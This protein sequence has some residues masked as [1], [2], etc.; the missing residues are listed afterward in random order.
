MLRRLT[1]YLIWLWIFFLPWQTRW[2]ISDPMLEGS[3]W[4]YGRISLYAG[5]IIF[6]VM[7]IC[8]A[9]V[10]FKQREKIQIHKWQFLIFAAFI[11][12]TGLSFIWAINPSVSAHYLLRLSQGILFLGILTI[13]RPT[14][15]LIFSSL[16]ISAFIQSCIAVGQFAFQYSPA[17]KW[18]GL[19]GH[20][21]CDLGQ[22][23]IETGSG[24]FLRA[25]GSLP[26]PNILG[27]FLMFGFIATCYAYSNI[28]SYK[29]WWFWPAI[30]LITQ[31]LMLCFSRSAWIGLAV[32]LSFVLLV[33]RKNKN[34]LK[35]TLICIAVFAAIA[36]INLAANFSLFASRIEAVN[37]IETISLAEREGQIDLSVQAIRE[38]PLLGHGLGNYTAWLQEAVPGQPG[39][40]YQPVHNQYLLMIAEAGIIGFALFFILIILLFKVRI[41]QKSPPEKTYIYSL[42]YA[43]LIIGLFDHY[44]W[45]S[46]TGILLFGLLVAMLIKH[47]DSTL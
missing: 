14:Y 13:A 47:E 16:I 23:V 46:Y 15:K 7:V 24:R 10:W 37:R 9:I 40:F 33:F 41:F 3:P 2:I 27:G 5:D 6:A 29:I 12:W 32:A 19:A 34:I 4:E 18:L 45:T 30:I 25:Y 26:H 11:A 35:R 38:N 43:T 44:F 31:G 36:G 8:S 1:N 28:K 39:Y 17:F 20:N 22:S 21:P 42:M